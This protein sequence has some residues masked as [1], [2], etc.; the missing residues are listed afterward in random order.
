MHVPPPRHP[1]HRQFNRKHGARSLSCE[2]DALKAGVKEAGHALAKKFEDVNSQDQ[3]SR[4][5]GKV[6]GVREQ[7]QVNITRESLVA[8]LL[9]LCWFWFGLEGRGMV[10]KRSVVGR[11]SVGRLVPRVCVYMSG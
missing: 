1:H 5:Q 11:S 2:E 10:L 9:S 8:V 4:V 3:L 6:D 7:M